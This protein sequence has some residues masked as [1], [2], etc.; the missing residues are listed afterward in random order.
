M[1]VP[2]KTLNINI[3]NYKASVERWEL[4]L[5]RTDSWKVPQQV[6]IDAGEVASAHGPHDMIKMGDSRLQASMANCSKYN[7][8]EGFKAQILIDFFRKL[9]S[10]SDLE[11]QCNA[12]LV[13]LLV[14]FLRDRPSC[15]L[16]LKPFHL[17]YPYGSDPFYIRS[18][19]CISNLQKLWLD[20]GHDKGAIQ[21]LIQHNLC[22]PKGN[23][24]EVRIFR[25]HRGASPYPEYSPISWDRKL[26]AH[27]NQRI[28]QLQSLQ[29]AGTEGAEGPSLQTWALH[30]DF[31]Q[32]GSL[33][34]EMPINRA[35][36]EALIG[37]PLQSLHSLG[38]ILQ[39]DT[40]DGATLQTFIRN[41]PNLSH[42]RLEGILSLP[43]LEAI[44]DHLD[45][46]LHT[47]YLI[48]SGRDPGRFVFNSRTIGLITSHCQHVCDLGIS[49]R[50]IWN[51]PG[52]DIA[53][54]KAIGRM[55]HLSSLDLTFDTIDYTLTNGPTKL[56]P[57]DP[58]FTDFDNETVTLPFT[59]D[60][61]IR[62]G[63]IRDGLINSA[64]DGT[65][66]KAVFDTIVSASPD[67]PLQQL[68]LR[69]RN[70]GDWGTGSF[71]G[72]FALIVEEI[73]RKWVATR[74]KRQEEVIFRRAERE[75]PELEEGHTLSWDLEP[76]FRRVW[77][78]DG[79]WFEEWHAFPLV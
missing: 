57:S 15:N 16:H 63:N 51:S 21:D 24:R 13:P 25:S 66:A 58:S 68:S 45:P 42:L 19:L 60:E 41:L 28:G 73:G 56:A 37:I 29:L 22:G 61:K 75:G 76:I 9:P 11:W 65:L 33:S 70:S 40:H 14:Q 10:L 74:A 52:E 30:T 18:I 5:E 77:P 43:A 59:G 36:L 17:P 54:L 34:L 49:V 8:I 27:D 31:A 50:R 6:I 44:L 35:T 47:L 3:A 1:A 48:P 7:A 32:L 46:A 79:D 53:I 55:P 2:H 20:I 38:L 62:K 69:S 71:D 78:G 64:I 39:K 72:S 26:E 4:I 12:L 23:L 67:P